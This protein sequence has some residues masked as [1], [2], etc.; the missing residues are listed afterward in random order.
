VWIDF[1]PQAGREQAKRR[2]AL[3]VTEESYNRASGLVVLC[4]LTSRRKG[5]PFELPTTVGKVPG[6]V[7]VDHIKSFDW[8]AR[9]AIFHSK[10]DPALLN[11]VRAY[12]EVLLGIR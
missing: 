8:A 12:L 7:L 4:A 1:D 3:V 2:P 5:Y 10:A 11:R 9:N 6:A